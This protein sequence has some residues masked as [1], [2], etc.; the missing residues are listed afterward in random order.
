MPSTH[1]PARVGVSRYTEKD[2]DWGVV[3]VSDNRPQGER[4]SDDLF[5]PF[6]PTR[7][8]SDTSGLNLFAARVIAEAHGGSLVVDTRG[9]S[10][11]HPPRACTVGQPALGGPCFD[12]KPLQLVDEGRATEVQEPRGLA[13]VAAGLFETPKNE[14]AF[15]LRD[16]AA[17][18]QSFVRIVT[19]GWKSSAPGRRISS[20]SASSRISSCVPLITTACSIAFSSW[21]TLPGQ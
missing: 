18:V 16:H 15:E 11:V 6:V 12:L 4:H 9:W 13:L 17:E 5:E 3:R 8:P 19:P 20:G 14:I 10:V 21:R 7:A 1:S 2:A